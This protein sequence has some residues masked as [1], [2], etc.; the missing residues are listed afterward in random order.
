MNRIDTK[1][2]T[3][4]TRLKD[5]IELAAEDYNVLEINGVRRLPYYT[6]YF[7][8][9]DSEM[10]HEH[11]RG[12]KARQKVRIR[13]YD[14]DNPLAFLEIKD[15]NNKGRTAKKR[16]KIDAGATSLDGYSGFIAENSKYEAEK[17]IANVEN[18]FFRITLV[19]KDMTERVTIDTGLQFHNLTTGHVHDAASLMIIEWKR[20]KAASRSPMKA[21]L[22][23]LHIRESGFSKYM[24]GLSITDP[25]L[26]RS[27]LKPRL[28]MIQKISSQQ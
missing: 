5:I 9:E 7:D 17:L 21:I 10:F 8:T 3:S 24:A 2:L 26:R 12:R 16:V 27:R 1:F 20:K 23:R 19:K 15:K 6:R 25:S 14:G 28:R 22:R 4:S 13:R 18:R 11:R